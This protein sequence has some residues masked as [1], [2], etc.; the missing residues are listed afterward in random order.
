MILVQ[1]G[2]LLLIQGLGWIWTGEWV[3]DEKQVQGGGLGLADPKK[4]S[5]CWESCPFQLPLQNL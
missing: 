2:G 4:G 5:C 1:I 3:W